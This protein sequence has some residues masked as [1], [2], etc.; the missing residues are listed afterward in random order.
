MP[1]ELDGFAVLKNIGSHAT[2]FVGIKSAAS[3]AAHDLVTKQLKAKSMTIHEMRE[4]ADILGRE[5]MSLI[6][7]GMSD[8]N[9]KSIVAKLDKHHPDLKASDSRWRRSHLRALLE[10]GV[11][12]SA[13]P[14]KPAKPGSGRAKAPEEGAAAKPSGLRS[15]AMD[16]FRSGL[17]KK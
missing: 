4:V 17:R 6:L 8:A 1:L 16:V 15:E 2:A 3:K 14:K 11:E 7:D 13:K 10:G 12:P 9:V 5:P